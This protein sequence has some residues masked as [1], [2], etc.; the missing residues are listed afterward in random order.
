MDEHGWTPDET[1]VER[2]EVER[3]LAEVIND[4]SLINLKE[5]SST[6]E[7]TEEMAAAMRAAKGDRRLDQ[8]PSE[9]AASQQLTEVI[10]W[11]L[12]GIA[13]VAVIVGT[14]ASLIF[15]GSIF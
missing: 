6:T 8:T 10:T 13:G 3:K 14:A 12:L 5:K 7:I 1:S 9:Q 2:S 11:I 4:E 15:G